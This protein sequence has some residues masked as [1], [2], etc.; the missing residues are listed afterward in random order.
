MLRHV[1]QTPLYYN[2]KSNGRFIDEYY[3]KSAYNNYHDLPGTPLYPFGYGLSYTTFS[4]NNISLNK[5]EITIN[6]TLEVSALLTNTGNCTGEEVVQFYIRDKVSSCTLPVKELKG[7]K[8]VKL[9]SGKSV[10]VTF[11]VGNDELSF[12]NKAGKLVVEP[13]EFTAY[14]GGNCLTELSIDFRVL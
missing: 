13:G 10:N 12:Y 9:E 6:D 4:Y 5:T 7:F 3:N 1:G 14:I 8:T 2:H 11:I